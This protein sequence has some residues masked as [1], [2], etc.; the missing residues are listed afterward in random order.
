MCVG[1]LLIEMYIRRII[2]GVICV[3]LFFVIWR[4]IICSKYNYCH[5]IILYFNNYCI[6]KYII[7]ALDFQFSR[8]AYNRISLRIH[9]L[10]YITTAFIC[11]IVTKSSTTLSKLHRSI[12]TI[13]KLNK[14][15]TYML[16]WNFK[17][18]L[19]INLLLY[20]WTC[21]KV[22]PNIAKC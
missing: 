11:Y 1:L 8:Y 6:Y 15:Y 5:V 16:F 22:V 10:K 4:L 7:N 20:G 12:W 19:S 18:I 2:C 21:K 14:L 13:V 9:L 3:R 17:K